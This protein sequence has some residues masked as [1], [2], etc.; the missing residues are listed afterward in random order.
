MD[1]LYLT[2]IDCC[3]DE[4][5]PNPYVLSYTRSTTTTYTRHTYYDKQ[6][7]LYSLKARLITTIF[8]GKW[9]GYYAN[10]MQLDHKFSIRRGYEHHIPIAIISNRNNLELIGKRE[11]IRKGTRCSITLDRLYDTYL[12]DARVDYY[13]E[14]IRHHDAE[15][16]DRWQ[17]IAYYYYKD[18]QHNEQKP[19][20]K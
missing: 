15:T 6:W 10:T 3:G 7:E 17:K 1:V 20:S 2:G 16:L 19:K 4:S 9:I 11:N 14:E 18:K 12:P 5:E 13:V 8:K